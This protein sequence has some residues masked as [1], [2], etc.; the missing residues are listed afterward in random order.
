M[1]DSDDYVDSSFLDYGLAS[2][3]AGQQ[4]T[5]EYHHSKLAP[6]SSQVDH[7]YCFHFGYLRVALRLLAYGASVR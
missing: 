6:Q 7:C 2:F 5:T 4:S 1:D 3:G